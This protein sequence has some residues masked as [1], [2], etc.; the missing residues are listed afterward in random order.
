[1]QNGYGPPTPYGQQQGAYP[2]APQQTTSYQQPPP[3]PQ[4]QGPPGQWQPPTQ[5]APQSGQ[6]GQPQQIQAPAPPVQLPGWG[7]QPPAMQGN[8]WGN[9]GGADPLAGIF[10]QIANSKASGGRPV[11]V[12]GAY[13]FLIQRVFLD[14]FPSGRCFIVELKVLQ[15]APNFQGVD[16]NPL[17]SECGFVVNFDGAGKKSA[18]SNVKR[19]ALSLFGQNESAINPAAFVEDLAWMTGPAQ[20]CMGKLIRATT[21][22]KEKREK[23]GE[24]IVL[25]GWQ[26][27]QQSP[28]D[29]AQRRAEILAAQ[30][31][32]PIPQPGAQMQQGQNPAAAWQGR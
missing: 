13:L 24:W 22:R 8:P 27:Q 16:P 30:A 6:Y 18:A 25:P 32:Q 11:I 9:Q 17:N 26:F 20:P 5:Y 7:T 29:V 4:Y 10:Q 28:D 2:G 15:C 12:D 1:M 31:G 19:F 3:G 23:K 14:S 21:Y